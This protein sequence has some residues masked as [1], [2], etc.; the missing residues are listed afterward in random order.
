MIP[1]LDTVVALRE[2][3]TT[4][5]SQFDWWPIA[6]A[7]HLSEPHPVAR[8]SGT[9]DRAAENGGTGETETEVL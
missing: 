8:P 1:V 9:R 7:R 2:L 5:G 6:L 3:T 4:I